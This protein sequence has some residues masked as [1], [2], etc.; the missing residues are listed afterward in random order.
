MIDRKVFER[1]KQNARMM[2]TSTIVPQATIN[3]SL[4]NSEH[5]RAKIITPMAS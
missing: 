5:D 2:G 1:G 4:L 3:H